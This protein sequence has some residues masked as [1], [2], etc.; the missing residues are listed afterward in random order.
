MYKELSISNRD[1]EP[2]PSKVETTSQYNPQL[3]S[4]LLRQLISILHNLTAE[5]K[6]KFYVADDNGITPL[7]I[8]AYI[9]HVEGIKKLLEGLETPEE[10]KAYLYME[11][12]N[13]RF[14]PLHIAACKGHVEVMKELLEGLSA[15]ERK[16]YL[17]MADNEGVTPLYSAAGN[18]HVEVIKELLEKLETPKERK[19][20]L[21]RVNNEGVTPLHIAARYGH[22]QVVRV[23]EE[24]VAQKSWCMWFSRKLGI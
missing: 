3:I 12:T 8:V 11:T 16:D 15:Q 9:G 2:L 4:I 14:T 21:N 19:A 7:H 22:S 23:F 6:K 10:R 5:Q 20:Y 17:H 13:E 24:Y 18:G 1:S